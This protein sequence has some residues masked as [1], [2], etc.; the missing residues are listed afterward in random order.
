MRIGID[1]SNLRQGG[2]R[3]HLVQML[4]SSSPSAQG[5]STVVVFGSQATLDLLPAHDW[6]LKVRCREVEAGMPRRTLWQAVGLSQE[7]RKHRCELLLAPGGN[8]LTNFSPTVTMCRNMLPFSPAERARYGLS[9]T[10]ARLLAL[11]HSQERT[12]KR[13]DGVIF[14]TEFARRE[15]LAVTGPI[16]GRVAVI[17]HGVELPAEQAALPTA[18]AGD[19]GA[20][21]IR[22]LY[23]SIVDVYK[24]QWMAV[25][26]ISRLR[27]STGLPVQLRLV[28]PAYPP[29]LRKLTRSIESLDPAGSWARYAG[30]RT[31]AQLRDEY[32]GADVGLFVS[33][34]ENMP[35]ILLE[36]M[37][38]GLPIV[39]SSRGPMPEVLG[40]AGVYCD[41][42]DPDSIA[43]QLGILLRDSALR[44]LLGI[45]ARTAA[46]GFRW[47]RCAEATF[48]FLR[49][50]AKT[51]RTAGAC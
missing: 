15:V 19:S 35:N 29:S 46:A 16:R 36:M 41:P 22:V 39:S 6:L 20:N 3:T 8:V 13:C 7:L 23:V 40:D 11:R 2:G 38:A 27:D 48:G 28:G 34:C 26:A 17:P 9:L 32:A 50:V 1:A 24:H 4:T 14:L 18:S 37:A 30:P 21:P 42:E 45:R 43:E 5:V 44:T 31:S 49:E 33:S 47:D 12:I 25:E 51:A 10:H